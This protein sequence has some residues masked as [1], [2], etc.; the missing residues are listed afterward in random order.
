MRHV[1]RME[2]LR[3]EYKRLIRKR[4]EKVPL[5]DKGVHGRVVLNVS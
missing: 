1:A 4:K 2:A 3:N 5:E